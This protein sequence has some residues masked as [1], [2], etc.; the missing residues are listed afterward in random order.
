MRRFVA[1][2]SALLL[3][4]TAAAAALSTSAGAST[5]GA[6]TLSPS[7]TGTS[8]VSWAGGPYSGVVADPSVCTDATC[9]SHAVSLKR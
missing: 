5:P 3:T 2:S 4:A 9:D 6:T 1:A 8:S 7:D